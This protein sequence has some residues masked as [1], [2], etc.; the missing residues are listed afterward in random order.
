MKSLLFGVEANPKEGYNWGP[1]VHL[2]F[3]IIDGIS[4][5]RTLDNSR[6]GD[7]RVGSWGVGEDAN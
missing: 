3:N 4:R 7:D 6:P 5:T 1:S 2:N